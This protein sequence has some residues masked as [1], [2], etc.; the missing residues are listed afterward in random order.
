MK[1]DKSEWGPGPWQNEADRVEFRAHGFPCILK[2]H[3]SSGHWCMYV[4][5]PPGH[6]WHGKTDST[7]Y[8]EWDEDYT[9]HTE[10]AY[11][12]PEIHG[13]VTYGR[14][15]DGDPVD[16]VCH[17]PQPGEPEHA[18]WIGADFHH[19]G[20]SA[21]GQDARM[22]RYGLRE[23]GDRYWTEADVRAEC[24]DFARQAA[25]CGRGAGT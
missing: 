8:G 4:G 2:R 16:G 7:I 6:P 5:V 14:G 10:P 11:R 9:H 1:C 24:E 12:K 15:S 3:P 18:W 22:R 13:G 19:S 21:P 23:F 20:D 17:V 25:D